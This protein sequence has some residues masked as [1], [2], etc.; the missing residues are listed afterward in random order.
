[1]PSRPTSRRTWQLLRERTVADL[2][3]ALLIAAAFFG[4]LLFPTFN[5]ELVAVGE[6]PGEVV[7][8]RLSLSQ[9]LGYA[10]LLSSG[11]AS[12][13]TLSEEERNER[14]HNAQPP[15]LLEAIS[16][17]PLPQ[18]MVSRTIKIGD[19]SLDV[20]ALSTAIV[21]A[22]MYNRNWFVR[23]AKRVL[24]RLHHRIFGTYP[25]FSYGIAQVKLAT[26]RMTVQGSFGSG[27]SDA[28][29]FEL[30]QGDCDNINVAS[31]Y[32]ESLAAAQPATGNLRSLIGRIGA[33]YSGAEPGSEGSFLYEQSIVGAYFLLQPEPS[34]AEP[35]AAEDKVQ[36]CVGFA[37][38]DE[39]GTNGSDVADAIKGAPKAGIAV[40]AEIWTDETSPSSYRDGLSAKRRAW[41]VGELVGMGFDKSRVTVTAI[42]RKPAKALSPCGLSYAT[43][44][45]DM[46]WPKES[47]EVDAPAEKA[48]PPEAAPAADLPKAG[49]PPFSKGRPRKSLD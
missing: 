17:S 42:G 34:E 5:S 24:G 10:T 1:V 39:T 3:S 32:I 25:N 30:L 18:C 21:A 40:H 45:V 6:N 15:W 47:P 26:A 23:S 8:G 31:R 4:V 16:A 49:V 19:N 46:P 14:R 27:L 43:I 41:V 29:L 12:L 28:E 35:A 11:L 48:A 44:T 37:R 7:P 38:G 13:S 20:Q 2:K 33:I 22:E 9:R 36:Y